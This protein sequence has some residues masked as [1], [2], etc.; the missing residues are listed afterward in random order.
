[1]PRHHDGTLGSLARSPGVAGRQ[2]RAAGAGAS[3]SRRRA[4]TGRD[5]ERRGPLVPNSGGGVAGAG[6]PFT[7]ERKRVAE[8]ADTPYRDLDIVGDED[9]GG[10]EEM[11]RALPSPPP[12]FRAGDRT[13]GGNSSS[14]AGGLAWGAR[15]DGRL[16]RLEQLLEHASA[17]NA[18]LLERASESDA[19]AD[20]LHDMLSTLR[21]EVGNQRKL[22]VADS[23]AATPRGRTAVDQSVAHNGGLDPLMM[24][25]QLSAMQRAC[26]EL[27]AQMAESRSA[28]AKNNEHELQRAAAKE[29]AAVRAELST[30]LDRLQ[31]AT[32]TCAQYIRESG[33]QIEALR[34]RLDERG[35]VPQR[36]SLAPCVQP[37]LPPPPLCAMLYTLYALRS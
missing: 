24:A 12:L 17:Q 21:L 5:S 8:V 18:A 19:R 7:P 27:T 26:D 16:E 14:A 25:G 6:A 33:G 23:S 1:M 11:N 15:V 28:M 13:A 22:A 2:G 3:S 32:H 4:N 20:S 30:V 34:L 31:E 35:A 10:E 36:L 9:E 37:S 29:S